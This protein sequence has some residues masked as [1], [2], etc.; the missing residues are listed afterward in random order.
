MQ[1]SDRDPLARLA[2]AYGVRRHIEAVHEAIYG[3][4]Y[5][6]PAALPEATG[7]KI[8][9]LAADEDWQAIGQIMAKR[10]A[11]LP[12]EWHGLHWIVVWLVG[13]PSSFARF[14]LGK[15]PVKQSWKTMTVMVGSTVRMSRIPLASSVEDFMDQ[16]IA[17]IA[18]TLA[19]HARR[20]PDSA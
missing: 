10:A 2:E 13:N 12:A 20:S 15:R 1:A 19:V 3:S 14:R 16:V 11:D 8:L 4:I 5:G 9:Q 18:S 7:Q 17:E 6:P